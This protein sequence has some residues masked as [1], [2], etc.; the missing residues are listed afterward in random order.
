MALMIYPALT[1]TLPNVY[2]KAL[3]LSLMAMATKHPVRTMAK[4]IQIAVS[5][6]GDASA[7]L[8][9]RAHTAD[10]KRSMAGVT[11]INTV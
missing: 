4:I 10:A 1:Q 8:K 6:T 9:R 2:V 5:V 3:A 7:I 11:A